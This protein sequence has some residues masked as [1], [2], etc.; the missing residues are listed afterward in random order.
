MYDIGMLFE[1]IPPHPGQNIALIVDDAHH[2]SVSK[3]VDFSHTIEANLYIKYLQMPHAYH[4]ALIHEESFS[5]D[6]AVYN[7]KS[8]QYDFLFLLADL[9]DVSRLKE[10]SKKIYRAIK[11]AANLFIV[12]KK[13]DADMVAM[14]LEEN[15]FVA[16]NTIDLDAEYDAISAKKMHGWMRV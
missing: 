7:S 12:V 3:L 13:Q 14:L 2:E 1:V 8:L 10:I 15:N 5:F 16:I 6:N 11:N 9:D 4:D